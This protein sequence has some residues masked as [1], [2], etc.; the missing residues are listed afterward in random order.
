MFLASELIVFHIE[1]RLQK[2]WT[3]VSMKHIY[4]SKN[5]NSQCEKTQ[6]QETKRPQQAWNH[7]KTKRK[8]NTKPNMQA[9]KHTKTTKNTTNVKTQQEISKDIIVKSIRAQKEHVGVY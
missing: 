2:Y 8:C 6:Q 5:P 1:R 4:S 7:N 3:F 9:R